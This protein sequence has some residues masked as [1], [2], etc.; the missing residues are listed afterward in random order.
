[1][2]RLIT[3]FTHAVSLC[4]IKTFPCIVSTVNILYEIMSFITFMFSCILPWIAQIHTLRPTY[5]YIDM[6]FSISHWQFIHVIYL[7]N[8]N[9]Y[10]ELCRFGLYI[11]AD[12]NQNQCVGELRAKSLDSLQA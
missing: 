7:F 9:T 1:M 12:S 8:S 3:N 4:H 6:Q 10:V 2:Y 11:I 5:T